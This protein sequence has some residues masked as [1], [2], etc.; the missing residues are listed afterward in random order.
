MNRQLFE[1]ALRT[2]GYG[3][4]EIQETPAGTGNGFR[5]HEGKYALYNYANGICM[6]AHFP[7]RKWYERRSN[8]SEIKRARAVAPFPD[9]SGLRYTSEPAFREL[10]DAASRKHEYKGLIVS[11][12]HPVFLGLPCEHLTDQPISVPGSMDCF[13]DR[14][15]PMLDSLVSCRDMLAEYEGVAKEIMLDR[16]R[17]IEEIASRQERQIDDALRRIIAKSL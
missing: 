12:P 13:L 9:G 16:E 14:I 7:E 6:A 5:V 2:G 10:A 11:V 3:E 1:Q 8:T 4:P 15:I 17:R